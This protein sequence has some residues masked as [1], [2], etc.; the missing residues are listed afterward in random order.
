[1]VSRFGMALVCAVMVLFPAHLAA[2]IEGIS[3]EEKEP[4]GRVGWELIYLDYIADWQPT[5]TGEPRVYPS[6]GVMYR[7]E[8]KPHLYFYCVQGE[9]EVNVST[10]PVSFDALGEWMSHRRR[11]R[12]VRL[13]VN[14]EEAD[15]TDWVHDTSNQ[16]LKPG[17]HTPKAKLYNAVIRGD[18][19]AL[20]VSG[21]GRI[22]LELAPVNDAFK[23]FGGP[24]GLGKFAPKV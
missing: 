16:V 3:A 12:R 20:Q 15:V 5:L 22:E 2:Q 10:E 7:P 18:D 8:D 19:I 23:A 21:K 9:L 4:V 1:M 14:G 6:E 13:F 24:C 17:R 11:I